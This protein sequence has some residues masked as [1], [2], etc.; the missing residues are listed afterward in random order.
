[1]I[2]LAASAAAGMA[3]LSGEGAE[4]LVEHLPGVLESTIEAHENVALASLIIG[5]SAAFVQ[6]ASATVLSASATSRPLAIIV[7]LAASCSFG[8]VAFLGG[9][10]H[11]PET[12][13]TSVSTEGSHAEHDDD[14]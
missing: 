11:H 1:M 8:Y 6:L 2:V 13:S 3:Y 7:V 10:I 9:K 14:D 4:E 12:G 5:I